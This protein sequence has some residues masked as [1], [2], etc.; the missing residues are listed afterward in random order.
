MLAVAAAVLLLANMG[1]G[2][3]QAAAEGP[4][5]GMS[6][7]VNGAQSCVGGAKPTKCQVSTGGAFDLV[8]QTNDAP[9]G[10]T[11][12]FASEILTVGAP[13]LTYNADTCANESTATNDIICAK[14][15]GGGGEIQ[16]A[17]GSGAVPPLGQLDSI[18]PSG[19]H[20]SILELNFSCGAGASA[21]NALVLT[22]SE[23]PFGASYFDDQ[24]NQILTKTNNPTDSILIN[25]VA[26][27]PATVTPLL[28]K[29]VTANLTATKV[30]VGGVVGVS[31]AANFQQDLDGDTVAGW[32]SATISIATTAGAV[33]MGTLTANGNATCVPA[34]NGGTCTATV[35]KGPASPA[36]GPESSAFVNYNNNINCTVV[37]THDVVVTATFTR[38]DGTA[39]PADKSTNN[40]VTLSLT[41][42]PLTPP[43]TKTPALSNLF[44]TNQPGPKVPPQTCAGGTDDVI[45]QE[46]VGFPIT[47]LDPKGG[48]FEQELAAFEFEVRFDNKL[49][50]V[51]LEPGPEWDV[52]GVTC[53]VLDK[54]TSL[55]EGIAR[56]AC[57]STKPVA[58]GDDAL[59][60]A[61]IV[62]R[63]QPDVYSMMRPNQENGIDVQILNQDCEL[64]DQL[65]HPIAIFSC[66]DADI[67]IRYLEGD[68][69]AD[70]DVD[71]VDGQA[72][73][74]RWNATLGN[75]LYYE[76]YDLEPSPVPGGINGDGD[77]DVKDIQF[78]FGRIGSTCDNPNPPQ[79][80]R[81]P[82][83]DPPAP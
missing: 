79:P 76:F 14:A 29:N 81:N 58:P 63:P 24:G 11:S 30:L 1:S 42:N 50:C 32:G 22:G 68:I 6:L 27:P 38:E 49:V 31:G 51:N 41:C 62:V 2:S 48:G 75:L 74:F 46:V 18:T 16:H 64:A 72:M 61:N 45:L 44:L 67:T 60:L 19:E 7:T 17:I 13:G 20:D 56:I 83:A 80:P 82:K 5:P 78:E 33:K 43:I 71:V 26:P 40:S 57:F 66:E 39:V 25:C 47:S 65:G 53:L 36:T 23:S 8:I 4:G 15:I 34:A 9:A 37:G 54:D 35:N 12:G 21:G 59:H 55:L 70:C 77:I 52:P 3:D 10:I 69:D 28:E 73:A